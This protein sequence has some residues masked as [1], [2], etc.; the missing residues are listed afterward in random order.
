[1]TIRLDYANASPNALRA[2]VGLETHLARQARAEGGLEMSILELVRIRVSQLNGCAY[3]L[4][5]H[6]KDAR[7]GG[8]TEQRLY[9]L[10]AWRETPFFNDR[11]QA[12]LAWAESLTLM[13]TREI[14]DADFEALT[15]HFSEMQ[16]ADLTLAICAI[17]GWNRFAV[18]LGAD[19]GSYQVS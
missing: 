5:M 11:E 15:P 2:M 18:G 10:S 3:C 19:V 17:N 4:D 8:E 14:R 12:A 9:T 16:I 13:A 6:S 7:A 1:M